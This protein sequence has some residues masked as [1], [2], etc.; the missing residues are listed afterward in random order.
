MPSVPY[1][2]KHFDPL[3]CPNCEKTMAF[4]RAKPEEPGFKLC[5]FQCR[6]CP[7]SETD[8]VK[9]NSPIEGFLTLD[10]LCAASHISIHPER[11]AFRPVMIPVLAQKIPCSCR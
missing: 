8:I 7:Y 11:R 10:T 4:I 1:W 9:V 5:T 6:E 3:V 2:L